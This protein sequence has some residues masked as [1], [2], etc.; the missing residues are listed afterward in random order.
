MPTEAQTRIQYIDQQIERA[1]WPAGTADLEEEFEVSSAGEP[2]HGFADYLLRSA[3]GD[4]LA[5]IEA[6]RTSRDAVAGKEQARRYA[7]AILAGTGHRPLI[8]LANGRETWYWDEISNPRLVSG[9]FTRGELERKSFQTANRLPLAQAALSPA[10]AG[11]PY[12]LEGVRRVH[13]AFEAGR[14]KALLVM[15]TGTGKTRV[16]MSLIDSMV[17]QRWVQNVL[18]L[19]DRR[20][21]RKQ[22]A[23]AAAALL[24]G[25]PTAELLTAQFEPNKRIY[26]ATLQTMQDFYEEFS[27]GAFD[28][29][30]TDECHRSIYNKWE[31]ILGYFDALQ[32]GLTATP[33]DF[34]DR[35]TFR[36]FQCD[37]GDPT[38][39]YE[40][41][42]GVA[43]GYLSPFRAYHARTVFQVEGI[44][45]QELPDSVQEE[46]IAAGI[47]PEDIDFA[48]TDLER[49]VTNVDTT[50]L[51]VR[52]LFDN[53]VTEP[54]GNLPGKTIVFAMSHAH[55]RRIWEAFLTEYPQFVGL[56]E[57]I[58][59]KVEDADR[60]LTRFKKESLP[61]I[62]ISVDMLDTGVDIPTVVNLALMKP[63]FSRIKFWQ[64]LGRGMRLVSADDAKPWCPEGT[65][66]SFRVL[67]FWGNFERFQLN[68][69]GEDPAAAA[70]VAVRYFRAMLKV[71][72]LAGQQ[73]EL[74]LRDEMIVA[75]R[76][77]IAALPLQSAGVR[78]ARDDVDRS[79][80]ET[81]WLSLTAPRINLL[82]FEIAPLMRYLSGIDLAALTFS[83][84]CLEVIV[85]ILADDEPLRE[86]GLSAVRATLRRLPLEH[87]DTMHLRQMITDAHSDT[88]GA[89]KGIGDLMDLR[90]VVASLV[91]LEQSEPQNVVLLDL[92]DAF[93]ARHWV[94]VGPEAT[95][96]DVTTYQTRV[97]TRLR[98]L[99]SGSPAFERLVAGDSLSDEE[100]EVIEGELNRPELYI[101][102]ETLRIAYR[103][104][105]TTLLALVRHALG[106]EKLPDR[107]EAIRFAFEAFV[108]QQGY[109]DADQLLF[110]RLFAR[111]LTDVGRVT[112]GDLFE[113]P[114]ARMGDVRQYIP[115]EDLVRLFELAARYEA[116]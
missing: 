61:R 12:Q 100:M 102:E 106:I 110:V 9:F 10:I 48:G 107:A 44:H 84:Q 40:Y 73:N 72:E 59:S 83:A 15:A 76:A 56:A 30:I 47:D 77:M 28:L 74:D 14:R 49:R 31:S 103:S 115:Q 22:A 71:A 70:P 5:L 43:E 63:V 39:A 17:N 57:I 13:D 92:E 78:E 34:L 69:Q 8:F 25:E 93:H 62:A 80:A 85:G 87:P 116:A 52:E 101:T 18:F 65:K 111:R 108:A 112:E 32:V 19:T 38:F 99:V 36:F 60:L 82:R 4:P 88:W 91:H 58:D 81:F 37:V 46:L 67:D 24:P 64:M 79:A 53:A 114:F 6:K 16:A 113:E 1:G 68:P 11:R 89:D 86:R 35:N 54:D 50:R 26:V 21:L 41:E 97:E 33:A 23:E 95:E 90:L 7:D 98:E 2:E 27:P 29:L 75:M 20:E 96:F 109:L 42:Q 105:T 66:T 55:A 104:P 3:S 45:G 51:L 94:A